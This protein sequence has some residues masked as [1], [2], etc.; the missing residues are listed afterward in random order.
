MSP[1]R[2]YPWQT[3]AASAPPAPEST[4]IEPVPRL[5]LNTEELAKA[6]G[7]SVGTVATMLRRGTAPP[8][9]VVCDRL[10][11]FPIDLVRAWLVE[12]A[13]AAQIDRQ[14]TEG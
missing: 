10:R 1:R 5:A 13:A 9:V 14:D 6:I 2:V 7:V 12:R 3:S 11:R 8:S 4:S